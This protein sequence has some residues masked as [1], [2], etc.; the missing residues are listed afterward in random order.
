MVL[1]K[2]TQSLVQSTCTQGCK[3]RS[4]NNDTDSS[5]AH[6]LSMRPGSKYVKLSSILFNEK[7]KAD[8]KRLG[9]E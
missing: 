4:V 6:S 1:R 8:R 2:K 5:V 9:L 7:I 3:I